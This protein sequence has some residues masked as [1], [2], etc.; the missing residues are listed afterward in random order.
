MVINKKV[1]TDEFIHLLT[2]IF[3]LPE[4]KSVKVKDIVLEKSSGK[5][6]EKV[7]DMIDMGTRKIRRCQ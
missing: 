5:M 7:Q 4:V 2:D 6:L 1:I 3:A